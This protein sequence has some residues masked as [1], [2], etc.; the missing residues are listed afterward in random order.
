MM[1]SNNY[2]NVAT[3]E[4]VIEAGRNQTTEMLNKGK[5]NQQTGNPITPQQAFAA[6]SSYYAQTGYKLPNLSF[7]TNT[8]IVYNLNLD[9]ITNTSKKIIGPWPY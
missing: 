2:G 6:G 8:K 3:E 1:S 9:T 5:L 7:P 4:Y